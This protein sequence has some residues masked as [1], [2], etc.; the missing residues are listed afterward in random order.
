[1]IK[2]KRQAIHN[3]PALVKGEVPHKYVERVF[4]SFQHFICAHVCSIPIACWNVDG[5]FF[6]INGQRHCK[7]DD[8]LFGNMICK[9]DITGLV[10]THCGMDDDLDLEGYYIYQN[11]RRKTHKHMKSSGGL[12]NHY[13]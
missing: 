5:L 12:K 13:R 1:M 3:V 7:L 6:R 10:E 9:F 4:R 8:P 11:K 2:V